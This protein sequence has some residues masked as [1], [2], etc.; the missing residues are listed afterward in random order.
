M[1]AHAL[2]TERTLLQLK[3]LNSKFEDNANSSALKSIL[4]NIDQSLRPHDPFSA[5]A[6]AGALGVRPGT[7]AA[8]LRER[9]RAARAACAQRSRSSP[10]APQFSRGCIGPRPTH[11]PMQPAPSAGAL[12]GAQCSFAELRA[13]GV[14]QR[15]VGGRQQRAEALLSLLRSGRLDDAL[16]ACDWLC[17]FAAEGDDAAPAGGGREI[18]GAAGVLGALVG[19]MRDHRGDPMLQRAC[20]R[21]LKDLCAEHPR[22]CARAGAAGAVPAV[23]RLAAWAGVG[24]DAHA[25][26]EPIEALAWLTEQNAGNAAAAVAGGAAACVVAAMRAHSAEEAVQQT[27]CSC[28]SAL[29]RQDPASRLPLC[30]AGAIQALLAALQTHGGSAAFAAAALFLLF[31]IYTTEQTVVLSVDAR[32][33][34][35]AVVAAVLR[36]LEAHRTD[37]C[38]Q[39]HGCMV[40]GAV[41]ASECVREAAAGAAAAVPSVLAAL[42]AHPGSV[43]V[44][45]RG[46]SALARLCQA[47]GAHAAAAAAAGARELVLAAMGAHRDSERLQSEGM[48]LL[49]TLAE[50]AAA[51]A[52]QPQPARVAA[53]VVGAMAAHRASA[54]VQQYGCVALT[55]HA[56]RCAASLRSARAAGAV[57]AVVGAMHTHR[58][59]AAALPP[60]FMS[61]C[62]E[63]LG[64][65][66][67]ST[68]E[69]HGA[70]AAAAQ[71]AAVRAGA[72]EVIAA[73][74]PRIGATPDDDFA[75]LQRALASAVRRHDAA[76]CAQNM[77][78]ERCAAAARAEGRMCALPGCTA[79]KRADILGGSAQRLLCC[80]RCERAMYCCKAHQTADWAPRHKAECRK[81]RASMDSAASGSV[82][83]RTPRASV[84]GSADC[85]TPRASED[86]GCSP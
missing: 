52:A 47:S 5:Q 85:L 50:H 38:V 18:A 30:D 46:L 64:T 75:S 8:P 37:G 51:G 59:F 2:H 44:Q 73:L 34:A 86:N 79:R 70:D 27:G 76:P 12:G 78:C 19:A 21:A 16:D 61:D 42:R 3:A 26:L 53:A 35:D 14:V 72:M 40:L 36:A 58:G 4:E 17:D 55:K 22:N 60:A 67:M 69:E 83:C 6:A 45:C 84:H 71:D 77:A 49:V 39:D 54:T 32:L 48:V 24:N 66:L 74:T 11:R 57:K 81:A 20:C 65:L 43:A 68:P 25:A 33:H 7:R 82:G 31:A 9:A 41:A 29:A 80:A 63:A 1:V 28:L 15:P 10:R 23:L 56:S 62:V 13:A